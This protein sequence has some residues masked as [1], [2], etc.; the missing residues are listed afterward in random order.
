MADM[1]SKREYYE[2]GGIPEGLAKL[3][4]RRLGDV[5]LLLDIGCGV[6]S[7]ARH[8]EQEEVTV[9]GI[10]RDERALNQ[11]TRFG[12]VILSDLEVGR[13]PFEDETFDGVVA[14]DILE[15]LE[16]PER[17]VAETHRV[18]CSG[19]TAVVS[20]PM[21]KPSVVWDDYTHVRGFTEDALMTMFRD[22][23][24]E[25]VSVTPMGGV[26]GA[27]KLGFISSLPTLLSVPPFSRFAVS[28]KAIV[29]K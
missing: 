29:E 19:G 14:K 5:E 17:L 3:Y 7:F 11:A 22:Y 4:L 15:H 12:E 6:G 23:G 24:F 21:P 2:A 28:H 8:A 16:R 18:L 27:E 25:I 13:L 10:D 9:I 26:P 1:V 20:V